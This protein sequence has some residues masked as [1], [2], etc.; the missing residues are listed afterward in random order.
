MV[1]PWVP[2][3]ASQG[4]FLLVILQIHLFSLPCRT[5]VCRSPVEVTAG[6][7]AAAK[8]VPEPLIKVLLYPGAAFHALVG[9]R[10]SPGWNTILGDY[11]MT[12]F[13]A[14]SKAY[15]NRIEVVVGSYFAVAGALVG[16]FKPGRMSLF[17]I[18]FILW[19]V[20]KEGIFER[21][22][23]VESSVTSAHA[24]PVLLIALAL[25]GLGIRYD[26]RKVER[27]T[28]PLA[29]PLKSSQ[30]AKLK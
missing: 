18:L 9:D 12:Q 6:Q 15:M 7:M 20:L 11:N 8:V 19:G 26:L 17:G 30:K 21:P 24:S 29:R 1:P 25:A 3:K 2:A 13:D 16:L 14:P 5:G 28:R 10:N 22:A 27:L 23:G 4:F